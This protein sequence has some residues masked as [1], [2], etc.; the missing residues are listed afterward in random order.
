MTPCEE[1]FSF[2]IIE[3]RWVHF[4][5]WLCIIERT[6]DLRKRVKTILGKEGAVNGCH[7]SDTFVVCKSTLFFCSWERRFCLKLFFILSIINVKTSTT[8]ELNTKNEHMTYLGWTRKASETKFSIHLRAGNLVKLLF[9]YG[10]K[11]E[12]AHD[13]AKRPNFSGCTK[14][15]RRDAKNASI[16]Y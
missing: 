13:R 9:Q 15:Q 7:G 1:W 10:T 14:G 16:S 8:L 4:L 5:K 3:F 12:E 2:E 6:G 11:I